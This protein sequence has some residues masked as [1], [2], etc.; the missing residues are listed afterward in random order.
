MTLTFLLGFWGFLITSLDDFIVLCHL[1]TKHKRKLWSIVLG[2]SAGLAVVVLGSWIAPNTIKLLGVDLEKFAPFLISAAMCYVAYGITKNDE[3][4][5]EE[6]PFAEVK[7]SLKV[8]TT[9]GWIY[10]TN[11]TDDLVTYVSFLAGYSEV[12]QYFYIAGI[13]TGLIILCFL[14]YWS[15]NKIDQMP[16][17]RQE[18]IKKS[19]AIVAVIIALTYLGIGVN[20]FLWYKRS[21]RSF[22]F[23]K[24]T[25]QKTYFSY[26]QN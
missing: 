2:T 1:F 8:F 26:N 6:D 19:F 3:E 10:I 15:K 17:E 4:E 23:V 9:A 24:N 20:Q 25:L 22:F 18:K 14:A 7:A 12:E 11:G 13:F 5:P 21:I 16:E